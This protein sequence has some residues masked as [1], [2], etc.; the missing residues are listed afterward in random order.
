LDLR[1]VNV[2]QLLEW[3]VKALAESACLWQDIHCHLGDVGGLC[4]GGGRVAPASP[5]PKK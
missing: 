5:E 2:S 1:P 4:E 3:L